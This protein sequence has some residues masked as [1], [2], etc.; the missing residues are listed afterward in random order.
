MCF[1]N[2][3]SHL[4]RILW[5]LSII[6]IDVYT[7]LSI[8]LHKCLWSTNFPY[9]SIFIFIPSSFIFTLHNITF[10]FSNLTLP[11]Y[12][13]RFSPVNLFNCGYNSFLHEWS[14]GWPGK[15][16]PFSPAVHCSVCGIWESLAWL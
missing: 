11:S 8:Y 5:I 9:A 14:A 16:S 3:S 2:L 1:L 12:F 15:V 13:L 10:L 4:H 7:Y 6:C